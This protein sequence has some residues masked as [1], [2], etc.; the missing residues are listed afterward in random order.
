MLNAGM[1]WWL[2]RVLQS[3]LFCFE[4][5][6]SWR[7][8]MQDEPRFRHLLPCIVV[9]RLFIVSSTRTE[10]MRYQDEISSFLKRCY[11]W[12]ETER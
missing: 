3:R 1:A 4:W 5:Q 7:K 8:D 6:F 11:D 12:R 2:A 9:G 10:R